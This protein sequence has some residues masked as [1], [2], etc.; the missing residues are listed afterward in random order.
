MGYIDPIVGGGL[1][2][3]VPFLLVIIV[4]MIRPHGIFGEERIE[5]L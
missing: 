2:Q 1:S 5:R 4:L 3:V